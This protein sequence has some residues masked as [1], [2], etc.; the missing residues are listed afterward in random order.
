MFRPIVNE[1]RVGLET[2]LAPD[3]LA[4]ADHDRAGQIV[5]NLVGNAVRFTPEG[6]SIVV[7]TARTDGEVHFSIS[8]TGP[9]ISAEQLQR[10]WER[11]WRSKQQG[12]IGLG[13]AIAKALVEVH[14]GRI[15]VPRL[16]GPVQ[17]GFGRPPSGPLLEDPG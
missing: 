12:G 10:I 16:R 8:D 14:G 6:G 4:R 11:F 3:L 9:G 17:H 13:L 1:K 5:S 15:W 7:R 2:E